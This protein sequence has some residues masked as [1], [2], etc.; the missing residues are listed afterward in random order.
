MLKLKE[1]IYFKLVDLF[2]SWFQFYTQYPLLCVVP[3]LGC[4]HMQL[5][6]EYIFNALSYKNELR[7]CV[8]L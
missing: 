2:L 6:I 3:I 7:I 1:I 4:S 5:G 8:F